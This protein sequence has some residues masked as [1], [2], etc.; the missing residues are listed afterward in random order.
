MHF[1]ETQFQIFP[2]YIRWLNLKFCWVTTNMPKP[3][4]QLNK[5]LISNFPTICWSNFK[6]D[7]W[8]HHRDQCDESFPMIPH[9]LST[10]MQ[11]SKVEWPLTRKDL[12]SIGRN[13][14]TWSLLP[15]ESVAKRIFQECWVVFELSCQVQDAGGIMGN[16]Y[17]P[18]ICWLLHSQCKGQIMLG[19]VKAFW[20]L[21]ETKTY[22]TMFLWIID[23]FSVL[24]GSSPPTPSKCSSRILGVFRSPVFNGNKMY[25]ISTVSKAVSFTVFWTGEK[26]KHNDLSDSHYLKF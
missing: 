5:Y 14:I 23:G 4:P 18:P 7:T 19:K 8:Y 13:L 25:P 26:Y 9:V 3:F 1:T 24:P 6:T 22:R 17:M 16:S 10:K 12:I 11:I 20:W 21:T 15:T 2:P